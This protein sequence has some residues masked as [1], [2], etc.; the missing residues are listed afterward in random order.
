VENWHSTACVLAA[1]LS[2][3]SKTRWSCPKCPKSLLQANPCTLRTA[4][5]CEF[6]WVKAIPRSTLPVQQCS[7]QHL[8]PVSCT[9]RDAASLLHRQMTETCSQLK[10]SEG[11]FRVSTTGLGS[12]LAA[13]VS[14]HWT[15]QKTGAE[16]GTVQC[17][18]L[19]H[20]GGDSMNY[21]G[22]TPEE[23]RRHWRLQPSKRKIHKMG[24]FMSIFS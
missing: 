18:Q 1:A 21:T 3:T 19:L 17:C 9:G 8:G 23:M 15:D 5:P 2:F 24:Y 12:H 7:D 10:P 22:A 11:S 4:S 16:S 14:W 20:W 6:T 13:S